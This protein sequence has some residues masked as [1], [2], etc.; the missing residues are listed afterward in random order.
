VTGVPMTYGSSGIRSFFIDET[1]VIRAG[2]NS[3]KPSTKMDLPLA[4]DYPFSDPSRR[5]DYSAQPVY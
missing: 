2:D 1:G 5:I 3:G 4:S